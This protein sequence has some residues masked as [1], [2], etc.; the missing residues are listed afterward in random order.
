MKL[1]IEQI[2]KASGGELLCGDPQRLVTGIKTDSRTIAPGDLFVPIKG[3]RIDAHV[4]IDSVLASGAAASF[5]CYRPE[6]LP[7]LGALILVDDTVCALQKT[8]AYYRSLFSVP[9][10]G[11][12]GSVGKT[13][14]NEMV[15]L[16][17]SAGKNVMYT[18]GNQNSQVGLPLTIFELKPE[19]TAAVI[20]MGMSEFGEMSRLAAVARPDTA[21][22]TNIG[23]SHIGQLKTQENILLEK[24]HITDNWKNNQVLFLNGDDQLLASLPGKL[25]FYTVT[26]G[27]SAA[28]RWRAYNIQGN[29]SGGVDFLIYSPRGVIRVSLPVSGLHNVLNATAAIAA[30]DLIG[31][32][33]HAAAMALGRYTPPAMRQEIHQVNGITIID[34]T[35]NASPDS[36]KG[37]IDLLCAQPGTGKR[38]AVVADM[39]ELGDFTQKAHEEIG[40]YAAQKQI[41]T[42]IAI[43]ENVRYTVDAARHSG[44]EALYFENNDAA[45]TALLQLLQKGDAVMV[46]G[47]RSMHTETVVR[48]LLEKL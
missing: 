46:K 12:T 36:V 38:Y 39:K 21:I 5:T 7:T 9:V 14:T 30:A 2:V 47:S 13:T 10:I 19:H 16:A 34:D 1:T 6:H 28:G 18:K 45:V 40:I 48:Q 22:M 24:L 32:N 29:A 42:L 4:Y 8:A 43:G 35:Y 41:S 17:V 33:P 44:L 23:I 20:E 31:V 27:T 25:P 15:A 37:G 3:E 26:Y 11:I